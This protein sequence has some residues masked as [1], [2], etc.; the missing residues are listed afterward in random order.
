M[1]LTNKEKRSY[2]IWVAIN[3]LV[4]L[5]LGRLELGYEGFYPFGGGFEYISDYDISE[6]LAY[7]IIPLIIIYAVRLGKDEPPKDKQ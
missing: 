5:A 7:T 2:L 4:L 1:K 3:L 6:F